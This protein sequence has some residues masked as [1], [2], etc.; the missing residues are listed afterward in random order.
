MKTREGVYRFPFLL[1]VLL[2]LLLFIALLWHFIPQM[3][4]GR[5]GQ[6]Q[7]INASI[8]N[9]KVVTHIQKIQ[10][11]KPVLQPP[12]PVLTKPIIQ[13]SSTPQKI[14]NTQAVEKAVALKKQQKAAKQRQ[15]TKQIQID[16]QKLLQQQLAQEQ[17]Q[18]SQAAA[19]AARDKA[20]Q[21]E[22]DKYKA[23]IV[24]AIG[25]NWIVP[26]GTD[27]N[28][29]CQLLIQVAPGGAVLNVQIAQSSGN[30][31]LDTSA[32]NAVYKA[33][34]LPVPADPQLFDKFRQLRLTVRPE[35]I[36]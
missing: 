27:K 3:R 15:L 22:I 5:G 16:Q 25:Q 31:G 17:Q 6:T 21:T 32:I 11:A 23:L 7:I 20:W 28:L 9:P 1:A 4:M 12:K 30:D 13:P 35:N 24:Q 18:L 26:E 29:S 14:A 8:V 19:S 36:S 2:H 34:P 10:P 33:S